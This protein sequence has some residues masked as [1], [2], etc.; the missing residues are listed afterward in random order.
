M[1]GVVLRDAGPMELWPNVAA[2]A[3]ISVLMVAMS[4]R[5]FKKQ[6]I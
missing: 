5:N 1:R 3:A 4:V 2:L 6:T